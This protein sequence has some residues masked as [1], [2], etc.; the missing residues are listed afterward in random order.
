M[1]AELATHTDKN[2]KKL[3]LAPLAKQL[4]QYMTDQGVGPM[5]VA[6]QLVELADKWDQYDHRK[7]QTLN[8]W[9]YDALAPKTLKWFRQLNDA[10]KRLGSAFSK[11]LDA[12]AMLWLGNICDAPRREQMLEIVTELYKKNQQNPV[13][14]LQAKYAWKKLS[15]QA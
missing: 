14:I 7:G 6:R 1:T 15:N 13:T 11:H 9:V 10:E 4:R 2:E 5:L 8:S 3:S 12:R